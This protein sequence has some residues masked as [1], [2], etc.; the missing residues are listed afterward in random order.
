[1]QNNVG[2][3]KELSMQVSSNSHHDY[4]DDL[5]DTSPEKN[6]AMQLKQIGMKK[7]K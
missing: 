1:M 3:E 4:K 7:C 5:S 6:D 2:T